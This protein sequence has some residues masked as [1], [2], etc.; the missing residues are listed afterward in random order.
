MEHGTIDSR[1]KTVLLDILEKVAEEENCDEL[2]LPPLYNSIDPE[3][4]ST[5]APSNTIQFEYL[6][7]EITVENET[8]SVD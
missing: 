6:G 4:L 3:A 8:V 1:E 7:Y 2:D 5:L